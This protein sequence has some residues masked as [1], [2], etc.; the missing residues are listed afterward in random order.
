MKRMKT[1]MVAVLALGIVLALG[2]TAQAATWDGDGIGDDWN[3]G[4]NWNP[5]GVPSGDNAYIRDDYTAELTATP[6][7]IVNLLLGSL[8]SGGTVVQT[9]GTLTATG[10]GRVGYDSGGA[11]LYDISGGSV[12]F[13][14]DV[15]IA[16]DTGGSGTIRVSGGSFSTTGMNDHIYVG[17]RGPGRLEVIGGAGAIRSGWDLLVYAQG[18]I[19]A[20]PDAG[21]LTPIEAQNLRLDTGC[22]LDVEFLATPAKDD[23]LVVVWNRGGSGL[24]GLGKFEEA[25]TGTVLNEG[26]IFYAPH[27]GM[28]DIEL[29]IT[30]SGNTLSGSNN[31]VELTV[32]SIPTIPEPATMV[33]LSLGGLAGLIRRRRR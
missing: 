25:G 21:G 22:Q 17:F 6:P 23:V 27:P 33:L 2:G 4:D 16:Y 3:T 11:S 26:D 8:N 31:D 15:H 24:S 28:G 5:D 7:S 14:E 30:Y 29:Q 18:T 1:M 13:D 12:A 10:Y 20:K 9:G 19:A 32:L